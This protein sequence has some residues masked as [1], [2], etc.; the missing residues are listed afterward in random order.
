MPTSCRIGWMGIGANRR[1][2]ELPV[3][4]VRRIYVC[5]GMIGV[6]AAS[7]CSRRIDRLQGSGTG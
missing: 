5:W 3:Q 6:Y 2:Y 7:R 4:F 1:V